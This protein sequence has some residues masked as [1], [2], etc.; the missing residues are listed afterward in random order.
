MWPLTRTPTMKKYLAA[1]SVAYFACHTDVSLATTPH[2]NYGFVDKL[3]NVVIRCKDGTQRKDWRQFDALYYKAGSFSEGLA[4]VPLPPGKLGYIDK[5]GKV[6][7]PPRFAAAGEFHCGLACVVLAPYAGEGIDAPWCFINRSGQ[8]VIKHKR[9]TFSESLAA[10]EEDGRIGY[11]N[12]HGDYQIQP[13][14]VSGNPFSEGLAC[15]QQNFV[16]ASD[17]EGYCAGYVN[18]KG[19]WIISPRADLYQGYDF[20]EGMARASI[21]GVTVGSGAW[22]RRAEGEKTGNYMKFGYLDQK[23]RWAIKPQFAESRDFSEGMAVVGLCNTPL[24]KP[25]ETRY[26]YIDRS[27]AF[28]VP[29]R[30]LDANPFSEGLALVG[31]IDAKTLADMSDSNRF[32]ALSENRHY[33]EAWKEGFVNKK[34][35]PV[36]SIPAGYTCRIARQPALGGGNHYFDNNKFVEGLIRITPKDPGRKKYGFMDKSGN[37]VIPCI[38]PIVNDFH[39]GLA[40][41]LLPES[42]D[43]PSAGKP[44]QTSATPAAKTL[45]PLEQ[46]SFAIQSKNFQNSIDLLS[47]VISKDGKNAQAHYLLAVSYVGVRRYSEAKEEYKIV[48]KLTP[49]SKVSQ[50]AEQ[51]LKK[52]TE[53]N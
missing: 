44:S 21:P 31:E 12:T 43:E 27:G 10:I 50:L 23:G 14:F 36:L 4:A 20:H 7:I 11:L 32:L 41:V 9:G 51:G 5:T 15:V 26:G 35:Q 19:A 34:G 2:G 1:L 17:P 49:N 33:T 28:V 30:F 16:A 45:S 6:I 46:A 13:Q 39:E 29:P 52:L 8:I 42:V 47:L 3:G 22:T 24:T 38:Y 48:I 53:S 37:I 40:S 25:D 18:T